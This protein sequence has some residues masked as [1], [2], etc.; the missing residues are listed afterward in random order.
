[1]GVMV[2]YK[3]GRN[4]VRVKDVEGFGGK[5]RVT[6]LGAVLRVRKDGS[7]VALECVGRDGR[8]VNLYE[9]GVMREVLVAY[10][11]ARAFVPNPGLKSYV[12]HIGGEAWDNRAENLEW[13]EEKEDLRKRK[14]I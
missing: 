3:V 7:M 2:D 14:R 4:P 5:Y 12:R 11:V 1:M 6:S 10:L 13:V 8:Y 9:G